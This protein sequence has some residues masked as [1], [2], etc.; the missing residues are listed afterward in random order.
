MKPA[1]GSS[2]PCEK[3]PP[4]PLVIKLSQQSSTRDPMPCVWI[5]W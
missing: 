5:V 3:S 1:V 4:K 2:V